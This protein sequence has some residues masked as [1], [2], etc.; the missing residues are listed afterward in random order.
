MTKNFLRSE[1]DGRW[2]GTGSLAMCMAGS[3]GVESL[4]WASAQKKG[5]V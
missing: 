2:E 5:N 4:K 3:L 1:V